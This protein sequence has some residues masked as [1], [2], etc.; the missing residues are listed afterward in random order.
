MN[1]VLID[2]PLHAIPDHV[3]KPYRSSIVCCNCGGVGHVYRHCNLP[4][5]SYGVICYRLK[6][7][8]QTNSVFP[9]YLMVQ[10]KDSLSY[11]EFMRGKYDLQNIS[12]LFKL[13]G[14]MT[15]FERSKVSI[16]SFEELWTSLWSSN[17]GK[18]FVK[19]YNDAKEKFDKLKE[20]YLIKNTQNEIIKMSLDYILDNST[21]FI[22][23]TEWGFPKGRRNMTEDDKRCAF[24]EFKEETG[25]N[26]RNVRMIPYIKPIEETFDGSNKVRYRHVYYIAKY[27]VNDKDDANEL[28]NP[29]NKH[30]TREIR[31]VRWFSYA[32]AQSK[33]R[34]H[35][36]E[37]KE[38]LKRVNNVILRNL[39]Y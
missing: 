25:I 22:E 7:D 36:S 26:M 5:T 14:N 12:Y 38:L 35:N 23:E 9:E 19:E 28:Y 13:F 37:R 32:D 20:G 2:T 3:I 1:N 6:Y 11:V 17:N 31:D 24:R 30:Q 33:I 4:I 29:N 10:R 15:Q 27:I 16:H 18:S 34:D 21:S 8:E 39:H